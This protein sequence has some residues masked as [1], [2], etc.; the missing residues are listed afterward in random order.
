MDKRYYSVE[1]VAELWG[2]SKQA[3][4]VLLRTGRLRGFKPGR[5]WRISAE[6]LK[7]YEST[8]IAPAPFAGCKIY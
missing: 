8:P 6:A 7:D 5:D 4:Y 3:I 1:E 2:V